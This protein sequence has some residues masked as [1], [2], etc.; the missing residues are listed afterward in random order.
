[1]V[2]CRSKGMYICKYF[3]IYIYIC[4]LYK[5]L[6]ALWYEH[7]GS[8]SNIKHTNLCWKE[9]IFSWEGHSWLVFERS[10]TPSNIM[11]HVHTYTTAEYPA[12]SYLVFGTFSPTLSSSLKQA[13]SKKSLHFKSAKWSFNYRFMEIQ[14][15]KSHLSQLWQPCCFFGLRSRSSGGSRRLRQVLWKK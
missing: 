15:S 6:E 2:W 8:I 5:Y 1:M 10:N 14:L 4:K 13:S 7:N 12:I 9:Q 3:I 11:H